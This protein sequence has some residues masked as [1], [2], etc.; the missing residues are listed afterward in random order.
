MTRAERRA[1]K[2]RGMK[3]VAKGTYAELGDNKAR[4][5]LVEIFRQL[6]RGND[7]LDE[8]ELFNAN[9]ELIGAGF[10]DIWIVNDERQVGAYLDFKHP[11]HGVVCSSQYIP[12]IDFVGAVH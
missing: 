5:L 4:K 2:S 10:L 3:V 12:V 9:M 8:E 11:D 1:L 7:F 6:V